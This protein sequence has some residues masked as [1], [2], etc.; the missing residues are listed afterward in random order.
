MELVGIGRLVN[1]GLNRIGLQLVR[2]AGSRA[3]DSGLTPDLARRT[4]IAQQ[5]SLP[6]GND[7]HAYLLSGRA[8]NLHKWH[9]FFEIYDIW[10]SRYRDRADLRVLEI[11]VYRGGSLKM[12]REYFHD[13]ATIVGLDINPDCKAFEAPSAK[14]FVEIGDQAD[15]AFLEQVAETHGPFDIIIDDGGHTTEQ[16]IVSFETLYAGALNDD[17]VYLVEDLHTNYWPEFRT[18]KRTFMEFATGLVDHLHEPYFSHHSE[19]AFR[20]G[21][22][23][24]QPSMEVSAFCAN[25]QTI[26]FYD[27]IIVFQKRKKSMPTCQL[28]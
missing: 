6:P 13:E 28:W 12:W 4:T 19:L 11:G 17:G 24:Q 27:S 14:T 23:E 16:Q 7:L 5:G 1:L 22:A 2:I 8:E 10:F 20:T 18:S 21:H 15:R 25:T 26:S 9:H 3:P